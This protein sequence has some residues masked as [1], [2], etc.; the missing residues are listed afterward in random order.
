MARDQGPHH[1]P[2]EGRDHTEDPART[3]GKGELD[4]RRD[5]AGEPGKTPHTEEG[6][7]EATNEPT[8]PAETKRR[9]PK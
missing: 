6:G 7:R 8:H 2:A 4:G 3:P 9:R 1:P 5:L